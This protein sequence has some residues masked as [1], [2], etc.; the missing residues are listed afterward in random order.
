MFLLMLACGPAT[1]DL[2]AQNDPALDDSAA[3]VDSDGDGLPDQQ[4][5]ELGTDPD[6]TDSDGD[7]WDDGEELDEGTDPANGYSHPYEGG[8]P[9]GDCEQLP[10]STGPTGSRGVYAKGD[11]VQNFTL[12]DQHGEEVDLY[13]FCGRHVMLAIG[14]EWCSPCSQLAAEAQDIQDSYDITVIEVLIE[15]RNGG[16]PGQPALSRWAEDHG[17]ETVPVLGDGDYEVF[18]VFERDYAIPTIVHIGPDGTVLS[19]DE[20]EHDPGKFL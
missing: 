2:D 10:E 17:L 3:Q 12:S 16:S 14:A 9:L 11:V 13:S 8:Y 15:D 4:E 19:V 7:G 6:A 5:E 1:I 18:S 20:G